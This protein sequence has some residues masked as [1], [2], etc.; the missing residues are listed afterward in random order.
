MART[1]TQAQ[2]AADPR[3][4]APRASAPAAS[5][6][7]DR[8]PRGFSAAA[9][10]VLLVCVAL[11]RLRLA[12]APLE[13]DEGEYGYAGQLLLQGVAP[14]QLAY[15][16]KF[17]GTYYVYSVMLA[18]FG[19]TAW[20]IHIGLLITNA[21]TTLALFFL[22]RRLTGERA[23]LIAAIAFAVLS[24]DRWIM[25]PFAHATHFVILPAIAGLLLLDRGVDS[26]RPMTFLVAGVLLGTSVL[27]KQHAAVFVALGMGLVL[28]RDPGTKPAPLAAKLRRAGMLA[29]GALAPFAVL[30][31][32]LAAQGVLGR[33][34]LWTI[35][36]ARAY[37]T[38]VP[39]SGA[40]PALASGLRTVTVTT[41]ALWAIAALGL[42]GLWLVPWR[43]ETRT[44]ACAFLVASF[45]ATCPGFYFRAHYF[46]VM[47]PALALL[48]GVGVVS[49]QRLCA[50]RLTATAG[51]AVAMAVF[52]AALL[53]YVVP[54]RDYL[55]AMTGEDLT[56]SRYGRNPFVEAPA[57]A[58]YIEQRTSAAD[59]IAVIG[60]EPEIYFYAR[61]RS[62][63][64]YIYMYPL[65]EPQPLAPRMQDEM[66]RDIESA[67]PLF[68]VFVRSRTSWL[69]RPDSDRRILTWA[70]HYLRRC[71]DVVGIAERLPGGESVLRW[72]A[73]VA[74]YQPQGEDLTYTLRR[75]SDAPCAVR[76]AVTPQ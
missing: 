5:P 74:G 61:R 73:E 2:K 68:V 6:E 75:R 53:A 39:W 58:R 51:T 20:A 55:F 10:G 33:F 41:W 4:Q 25:G 31:A 12:G 28:W 7:Q 45:L 30:C 65:M 29:L 43:R 60:S 52:V 8:I 69:P 64:G 67:H 3:Q 21:C 47:L 56:R 24:L 76:E 16:M 57:I 35:Q 11:V 49:L 62:A 26:R 70:D 1:R 63:T 59:R 13:R 54:E 18:L 37:A 23:A 9:L 14:Y 17:P 48:A 22:A 15:N 44:F 32:R 46:I 66:I 38:E 40:L 34:S 27:M 71:Y 72:D 42:V 36:Y 50:S 19:H